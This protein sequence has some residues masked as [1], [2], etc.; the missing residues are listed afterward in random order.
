[1]VDLTA[2]SACAGLLPLEIGNATLEEIEAGPLTWVSPLGDP[3]ALS[4]A[5]EQA[6]GLGWPE[7]GRSTA[8]RGAR[9][10]WFGRQEAL[11]M[12]AAPDPA[13][14]EHAAIVDQSDAWAVVRLGGS[15]AVDV[16]ARLVPVDLRDAH[17]AQGNSIRTQLFHMNASITKIGDGVFMILVFRSMA[18]TLVHDLKGAMQSVAARG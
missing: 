10:L 5:L 1:M 7:P 6:H 14:R 18:V 16:L 9:C 3:G 13:L 8:G 15:A 12:G 2:R 4:E 11:L 17:F